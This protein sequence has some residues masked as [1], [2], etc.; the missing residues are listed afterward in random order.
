MICFLLIN[1]ILLSLIPFQLYAQREVVLSDSVDD[2]KIGKYTDILF[3]TSKTL[4]INDVAFGEAANNFK[5]L[6]SDQTNLGYR[7]DAIWLRFMV[8]N[9][10]KAKRNWLL[11]TNYSSFDKLN[12]YYFSKSKIIEKKMGLLFSIGKREIKNR[13]DTFPFYLNK[14]EVKEFYLRIESGKS[15]PLQ[16]EIWEPTEFFQT[17]ANNYLIFGLFYGSLLIMS[18]Y[19]LFLFFSVKDLSYLFYSIYAIGVGYYQASIDGLGFQFLT[20][21]LPKYNWMYAIISATFVSIGGSLFALEFLQIKKY[22]IL[23]DKLFKILISLATVYLAAVVFLHFNYSALTG[24]FAVA[25]IILSFISGIYSLK[26]GNQNAFYYLIAIFIFLIGIFT[27]TFR[28]FGIINESFISEYGMQIGILVE[29]SILSFALGNRINIIKHEEE[30]EKALIRSR[31]ASDLHDEIGSNLSSISVSS[32]M[33]RK[34][35]SIGEKEKRQL[36]DIT[37]TAKE[38]ADSIRDI[39]WFINPEHDKDEDLIMKMKAT[40]SKILAGIEFTFNTNGDK[41][42]IIKDLKSRRNLFMIFKETLNNIVKHSEAK[43]VKIS[44]NDKAGKFSMKIEDDGKGFDLGKV[45]YGEG[46]KNIQK[47]V[48]EMNGYLEINSTPGMGTE[49]LII[50]QK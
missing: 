37:I 42:I 23:L 31:I 2:Y 33:I 18:L 1:I 15:I 29:M 44:I 22:S 21:E 4:T 48:K 3:D 27:R 39:I 30:K 16:I 41:D 17:E 9:E 45:N 49:I 24:P 8:K 36:E 12:Y 5:P 19:N 47:R 28:L 6:K 11:N 40:A 32:Q 35:Q 13:L 25:Y 14:G 20:P 10:S 50:L 46:L 38:T 34:S 26:K 7:T 43:C